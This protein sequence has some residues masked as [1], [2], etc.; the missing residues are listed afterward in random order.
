MPQ[1]QLSAQSHP[2]R[3]VSLDKT[4]G[5][6]PSLGRTAYQITS[7]SSSKTDLI[8]GTDVSPN[9]NIGVALTYQKIY[10]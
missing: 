7:S 2:L 9:N 3:I 8:R 5:A 6:S 1:I 10:G 4:S